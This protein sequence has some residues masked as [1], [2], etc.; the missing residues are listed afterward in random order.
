MVVSSGSV[1]APASSP[2][3]RRNS[4]MSCRASPTTISPAGYKAYPLRRMSSPRRRARRTG[5]GWSAKR[6]G[7]LPDAIPGGLCRDAQ[8]LGKTELA[9][10]ADVQ[11]PAALAGAANDFVAGPEFVHQAQFQGVAA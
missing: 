7:R 1:S 11:D 8:A 4:G 2:T 5:R 3:K 6:V 10:E 9:L